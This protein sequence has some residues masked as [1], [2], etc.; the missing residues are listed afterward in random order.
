MI[1]TARLG[2]YV[3]A[4]VAAL[5]ASSAAQAQSWSLPT[6]WRVGAIGI[7]TP[8]YEG[9]SSYRVMG[10]PYL[11]P[12]GLSDGDGWLQFKGPDD[13]RIRLL[14]QSGF[15]LGPVVGWRFGRDE[16][17]GK[18]L[19]GLGDVEGGLVVGGYA[20]Y[21]M[22][23]LAAFASYQHQV[24]G[25]ETGGQLRLGLEAR[26][27]INPWLTLTGTVGTT[28]AN[29]DYMDSFFG[30]SASQSVT[31]GLAR[32]DAG[33]G[34]KDVFLGLGAEMPLDDRWTLSVSGRY[35]RL[36]GDAADSPIVETENQLTGMVGLT[37]KFSFTR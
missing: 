5:C 23:P 25:D 20:A 36:V 9:S 15:E 4:G 27:K 34:I 6:E 2:L 13:I 26:S 29:N 30:V 12:A 37:Y 24:T 3:T 7:V 16:E 1:S 21:R 18:R 19:A 35:S 31:S 11:A 14:Q 33:A 10:A 32:Y 22:G 28:W 17:D 8:K